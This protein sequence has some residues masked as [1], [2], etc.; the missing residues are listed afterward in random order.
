MHSNETSFSMGGGGSKIPTGA[1]VGA[2]VGAAIALVF[3]AV[4]V[5]FYLRS[6][7]GHRFQALSL[8]D[9]SDPD[10][11]PSPTP[12]APPKRDEPPI[13]TVAP[14][15]VP[16]PGSNISTT[17]FTGSQASR[18]T[19]D[20]SFGTSMYT[21]SHAR[22]SS[23]L[24]LA[25]VANPE[26]LFSPGNTVVLPV[27]SGPPPVGKQALGMASDHSLGMH[28]HSR[29]G[30]SSVDSSRYGYP[31]LAPVRNPENLF[32]PGATAVLPVHSGPPPLGKQA[33]GMMS[34]HSLG[35]STHSRTDSSGDSRHRY[36]P[37]LAPVRNPENLFS[38]GATAV[39]PVH[40]GPVPFGKQALGMA[41]D[42]SLG[43]STHSRN[44]SSFEDPSGRR[45]D[46]VRNPDNILSP[47]EDGTVLLPY[48][49]GQPPPGKRD[50]NLTS[51]PRRRPR[52]AVSMYSDT[53]SSVSDPS[54]YPP[55]RS[56]SR[57]PMHSARPKPARVV[58]HTDSGLRLN[59]MDT[60]D[61]RTQSI[62]SE[63]PPQYTTR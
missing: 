19:G 46:P 50:L 24:G 18:P 6:R 7:R 39:L 55:P 25:P 45:Y 15:V 60:I 32:S 34:D 49:R 8:F 23:S 51:D 47:T 52:G 11:P 37:A 9:F 40:S 38:P 28:S 14:F 48:N 29:S 54:R 10:R 12:F 17:D 36:N 56:R 59:D 27:H 43:A 22:S 62:I 20:H 41:S 57:R 31:A 53:G 26:N 58:V 61:D 63:I 35:V 21:A 5:F 16:P 2:A 30:S 13:G 3:V 44:G 1:L 42:H 4:A 33:L